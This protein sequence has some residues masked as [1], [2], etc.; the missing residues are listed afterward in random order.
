MYLDTQKMYLD[1]Q[2]DTKFEMY[3]RI[4]QY[5]ITGKIVFLVFKIF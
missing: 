4:L 1:T 5:L 3:P 2:L